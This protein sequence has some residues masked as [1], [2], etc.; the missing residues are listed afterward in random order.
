MARLSSCDGRQLE[1][2]CFETDASELT[3][4]ADSIEQCLNQVGEHAEISDR[5][6]LTDFVTK[7]TSRASD[8]PS[9]YVAVCCPVKE[10]RT[11]VHKVIKACFPVS[12][13]ESPLKAV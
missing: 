8:C 5:N 13:I 11:A 6:A 3:V 9:D 1:R 10:A 4:S 12:K 2:S 7:A